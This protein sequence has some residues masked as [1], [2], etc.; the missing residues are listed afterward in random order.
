MGHRVGNVVK[1]QIQED[2]KTQVRE[3]PNGSRALRGKELAPDLEHPGCTAEF[4][5]QSTRWT[6]MVEV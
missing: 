3:L 6:D 4:P 1:F 2:V 5:R